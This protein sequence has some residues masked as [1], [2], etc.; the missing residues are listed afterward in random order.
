[1]ASQGGKRMDGWMEL[2][3]NALDSSF[4]FFLFSF[5]FFSL[6]GFQGN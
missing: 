3:Q 6:F 2:G 4:F 5:S 1:M